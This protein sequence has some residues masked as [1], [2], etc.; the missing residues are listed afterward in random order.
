MGGEREEAAR[1]RD[2]ASSVLSQG[3]YLHRTEKG[4]ARVAKD[5]SISVRYVCDS[6][7]GPSIRLYADLYALLA[8]SRSGSNHHR[9]RSSKE[10]LPHAKYL[11]SHPTL[12]PLLCACKY[13]TGSKRAVPQAEGAYRPRPQGGSV[14]PKASRGGA[15]GGRGRPPGRRPGV[16]AGAATPNSVRVKTQL[17]PPSDRRPVLGI[18]VPS[19]TMRDNE[20][21]R[22]ARA[23]VGESEGFRQ[24]EFVW[25]SLDRPVRDPEK[26]SRFIDKWPAQVE[27]VTFEA[28]VVRDEGGEAAAAGSKDPRRR[29]AGAAAAAGTRVEQKR[30]YNVILVGCPLER[31]K[32]G[33]ERL[34]PFLAG[35]VDKDVSS[36]SFGSW[37]EHKWLEGEGQTEAS[38][39][40]AGPPGFP[41]RLGLLNAD[42]STTA[43]PSPN[44]T[45]C[46][47]ALAFS[48]T[49]C[50][51]M[52][53][54]WRVTDFFDVLNIKGLPNYRP[55]HGSEQA[56][57]QPQTQAHASSSTVPASAEHDDEIRPGLADRRLTSTAQQ[58]PPSSSSS[59]ST[60]S[61]WPL[62]GKYWQGLFLGLERVWVGDVVRL[63]LSVKEVRE[64]FD[65]LAR[66]KRLARRSDTIEG[67][68]GRE[69]HGSYVMRLRAIFR[70]EEEKKEESDEKAE[71]EQQ[72]QQAEGADDSGAA[73]PPVKRPGRRPMPRT[74][75]VGSVYQVMTFAS[76]E[77]KVK[78]EKRLYDER[79]AAASTAG[80]VF[81][82]VGR[83][84]AFPRLD[85]LSS[86]GH[87]GVEL[88]EM[89]K[90]QPG[91]LLS[92]IC[93]EGSEVV[94]DV[95][96]IAGRL[97]PSLAR[98]SPSSEGDGDGE[99]E[100][101]LNRLQRLGTGAQLRE[102]DTQ[103]ATVA[104][105]AL[106]G[107]LEGSVKRM[108]IKGEWKESAEAGLTMCYDVARKEIADVVK[109]A[110]GIKEDD[111]EAE[112]E[113]GRKRPAAS[114]DEKDGTLGG[115]VPKAPR[116]ASPPPAAPKSPASSQTHP[117]STP[118]PASSLPT[119]MATPSIGTSTAGSPASRPA[120]TS[121]NSAAEDLPLPP[122]WVKRV[123]RSGHGVYYA[124]RTTKQT[125]WERPTA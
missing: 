84:F 10:F 38:S 27:L 52:R 50:N 71:G 68:A 61:R 111:G 60:S 14:A 115:S 102:E 72:Q 101:D 32:V 17:L 55:P 118:G 112:T 28:R 104:R 86:W 70:D 33:E 1:G 116:R 13:C 54:S 90:L 12:N 75:I 57:S 15:G 24:G 89:A 19:A 2:V 21:M 114:D 123:S 98:P 63:N 78:E 20:L 7:L 40:S 64:M 26:A 5:G 8:R 96:H 3:L 16:G 49:A 36:S 77:A 99:E 9:F 107:E 11:L 48:M 87:E 22:T 91:F 59:S 42:G 34:Q 58:E 117:A 100:G 83:K 88:P 67:Q 69:L 110:L 65:G 119:P 121:S 93:K 74:R 95:T 4:A 79:A 73:G 47:G 108:G 109:E 66:E 94:L 35:F 122:G 46:L 92:P 43:N 29:G 106:A 125:T 44:W 97:Y 25:L 31:G 113:A 18:N 37:E 53:A 80:D 124:N 6:T 45:K 82:G 56:R 105:M 120:T 39:S 76:H 30:M 62:P 51:Y 85:L 23:A 41:P 81:G 103:I